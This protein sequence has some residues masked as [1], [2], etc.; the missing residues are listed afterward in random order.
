MLHQVAFNDLSPELAE[1][2]STLVTHSSAVVFATPTSYEP[3]AN[4]LPCAYIFCTEDNA[5]PYPIQQ[6]MAAQLG[7]D[8]TTYTVKAG[9]CAFLSVPDQL[10]EVIGQASEAG[11]K[12]KAA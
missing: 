3:W 12:K 11:L 10:L 6:Q 7:P 9:H 8:P 2:S 4:G 1:F 5:L